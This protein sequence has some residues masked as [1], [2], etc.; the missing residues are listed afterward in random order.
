MKESFMPSLAVPEKPSVPQ[1]DF[2]ERQENFDKKISERMLEAAK[3]I[4]DW[5]ELDDCV[6]SSDDSNQV[7]TL[8]ANLVSWLERHPA[9]RLSDVVEFQISEL[10]RHPEVQEERE[11]IEARA[12]LYGKEIKKHREKVDRIMNRVMVGFVSLFPLYGAYFTGVNVMQKADGKFAER[13]RAR[14]EMFEEGITEEQRSVYKFGLSELVERSIRPVTYFSEA[15]SMLF[16][17]NLVMGASTFYEKQGPERYDA[18]RLYLGLS[19]KH[20]TFGISDHKPARS[21]VDKYYYKIVDFF[22]K[23]FEKQ[24]VSDLVSELKEGG[25]NELFVDDFSRVMGRFTIT[26]GEDKKGH[27]ISYYDKWD[28]NIA[29]EKNGGFIGR[30][31]EIYDRIYYNPETYEVISSE[32]EEGG[33]AISK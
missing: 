9:S 6:P 10:E 4:G 7:A 1:E 18:W 19:Q 11:L 33:M 26:L 28:L 12:R 20:G 8:R 14:S 30:P 23:L 16:L 27:Y 29:T 22:P 5:R 13:D 25:G 21:D 17:D 3:V 31:F 24:T 2:P 32:V 15:H